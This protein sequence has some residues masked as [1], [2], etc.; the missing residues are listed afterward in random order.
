MKKFAEYFRDGSKKI[1]NHLPKIKFKLSK[2]KNY[3]TDNPDR[4][5]PDLSKSKKLLG[6]SCKVNTK[7]GIE[8]Y[9]KFL[10]Y[11]NKY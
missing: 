4:R 7:Q 2:D 11:E 1:L 8:N 9:I 5:C 6:Y 10:N 3:L